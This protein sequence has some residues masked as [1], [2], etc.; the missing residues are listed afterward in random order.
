MATHFGCEGTFT[1][2]P[3]G[4]FFGEAGREVMRVYAS[5]DFQVETKSDGSPVTRADKAAN[6]AILRGLA[7]YFPAD[8]VISET[9]SLYRL[10]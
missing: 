2:T 6:T 10:G 8:T 1:R 5:D 7:R 9:E 4:V 3:V